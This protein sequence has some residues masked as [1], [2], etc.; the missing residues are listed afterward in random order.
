MAGIRNPS[1]NRTLLHVCGFVRFCQDRTRAV[2]PFGIAGLSD[3]ESSRP[4]ECHPTEQSACRH[5]Q[6]GDQPACWRV[7]PATCIERDTH[8]P[9]TN[10]GEPEPNG[11]MECH[12]GAS[13]SGIG[14]RG[15]A[16]CQRAGVSG[17]RDRFRAALGL[18][19]KLPFSVRIDQPLGANT[20]CGARSFG[21]L[22]SC[23]FPP[24]SFGNFAYRVMPRSE[25]T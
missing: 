24:Q 7:H 18:T 11:R 13:V 19:K 21:I 5:D 22:C 25:E 16:R 17:D 3:R 4:P 6:E 20:I 10:C 23:A 8:R 12:R 15:H 9:A 2:A 1:Q 14:T